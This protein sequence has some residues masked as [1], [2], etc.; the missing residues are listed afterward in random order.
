M[1][2]REAYPDGYYPRAAFLEF[3]LSPRLT[4]AMRPLFTASYFND[5]SSRLRARSVLFVPA[6][7]VTEGGSLH[8]SV[9]DSIPGDTIKQPYSHIGVREIIPETIP[10][11]GDLPHG[12]AERFCS[13]ALLRLRLN[14][15][16]G[17]ELGAATLRPP[18][19]RLSSLQRIERPER[20]RDLALAI[21]YE[22]LHEKITTETVLKERV[23]EINQHFG[24]RPMHAATPYYVLGHPT[25]KFIDHRNSEPRIA[26]E[27][28]R[29]SE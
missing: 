15:Q 26:K 16:A 3:R 13:Q 29:A 23:D 24:T 6:L 5:D 19:N 14:R 11:T 1:T 10:A 18:T 2:Q 28:K 25:V 7:G 27:R 22:L 12:V 21:P 17:E 9:Y 20:S 8:E 4:E